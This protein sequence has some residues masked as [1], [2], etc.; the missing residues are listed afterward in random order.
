MASLFTRQPYKAIWTS[1]TIL[2][3]LVRIPFILLYYTLKVSRPHQAWTYRQALGREILRIWFVYAS[4]V[5]FQFPLS[6]DPGYEKE[7]FVTICPAPDRTYYRIPGNR[8]SDVL[9][10]VIGGTWFPRLYHPSH[11]QEKR[12]ILHFH[13]GAYVLGGTRR[14]ECG[15]AASNL[16]R[17]TSAMIFFPQYRLAT[18]SNSSFPAAFQDALTSYA[19]L[20]DLGISPQRII[21][22]GDSA[23]GHLAVT[24]LRH[25]SMGEPVLPEPAALLLWSPWLNLAADS[26]EIDRNRNSAT[27]FVPAGLVRWAVRAFAPAGMDLSHPYITPLHHPFSTRVPIWIQVGGA[28]VLRDEGMAFVRNM[29]SMTSN[30]V[31]V[32]EVSSAPHDIF[33]AGNILGFEREALDAADRAQQYL[34][35]ILPKV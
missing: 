9:P 35:G 12:V 30:R 33:L 5:E 27:D 13:G 19:Y 20:L 3:C 34:K 24:L 11:D 1:Y 23:G 25:L 4:T 6:L 18:A 26:K 16:I 28:E 15:F 2:Y 21:I 10:E 32:Y 14:S 17:S 31:G 7:D 8:K 22:S 29:R